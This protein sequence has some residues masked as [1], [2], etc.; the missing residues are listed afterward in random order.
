MVIIT[1]LALYCYILFRYRNEIR[2]SFKAALSLEDTLF[3]FENLTLD[4]DR[5]LRFSVVLIYMC[6]AVLVCRF[7]DAWQQLWL[8]AAVVAGLFVSG[9][10]SVALRKISSKF[11]TQIGHWVDISSISRL[12]CA[13]SAI[14]LTPS[15][16]LLVPTNSYAFLAGVVC[17]ILA[18]YHWLSLL[19][20]F[21]VAGFSILQW[22]LY[23]CAVE[24]LPFGLLA[25]GAKL[26]GLLN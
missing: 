25:G 12:N 7:V 14:V 8:W 20:Y 19:K 1:I 4:F 6:I 5:F 2:V 18:L 16:L 3:I 23:L 15:V 21:R 17:A 10:L 24:A 22:I 9:F 13:I 11:D 26:F